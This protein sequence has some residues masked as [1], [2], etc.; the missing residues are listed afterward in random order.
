MRDTTGIRRDAR[1]CAAL[2]GCT[3]VAHNLKYISLIRMLLVH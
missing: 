2:A 3:R 1:P